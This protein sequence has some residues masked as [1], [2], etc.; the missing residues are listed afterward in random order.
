M[1]KILIAFDGTAPARRA[2]DEAAA[3]TK[4]VKGTLTVV[5]VVPARPGWTPVDGWDE[6]GW[7]LEQLAKAK[8]VLAKRG[9]KASYLE[10]VGDPAPTIERL[11]R[12]LGFDTVVVGSRGRSQL[13]RALT[14]SVSEHVATH[15][16]AIVV[17]VH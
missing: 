16:G 1:R 15:A 14:G 3:L 4:A 17:I 10:P 6:I 5:S 7:H 8:A 13:A 11:A 2:L 9:V 12:E